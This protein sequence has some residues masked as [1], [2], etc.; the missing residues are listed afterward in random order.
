MC[1][2]T[3]K[4]VYLKPNVQE[5]STKLFLEVFWNVTLCCRLVDSDVSGRHAASFVRAYRSKNKA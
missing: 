5:Q 3:T 2:K 1:F 4:S